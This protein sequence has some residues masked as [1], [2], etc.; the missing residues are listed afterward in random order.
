METQQEK[1]KEEK[2]LILD[3]AFTFMQNLEDFSSPYYETHTTKEV[4]NAVEFFVVNHGFF[5]QELPNNIYT[6]FCNKYASDQ[7]CD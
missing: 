6:A 5:A 4:L 7:Q 2:E 3:K 1:W